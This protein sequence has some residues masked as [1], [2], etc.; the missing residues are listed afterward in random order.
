M[1]IAFILQAIKDMSAKEIMKWIIILI[2]LLFS[3]IS[4]SVLFFFFTATVFN[5]LITY[6]NMLY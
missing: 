5:N 1:Y 6:S 2:H 4:W 3:Q